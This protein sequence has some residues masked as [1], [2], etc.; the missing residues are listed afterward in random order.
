[1][2]SIIKATEAV[3][4]SSR[5]IADLAAARHNDVIATIDRLFNKGLLR[6]DRKSRI[7]Q[8]GGRPIAVYDLI[9]RDVYLVVAGYSDEIR[10][11]II[12]RWQELEAK[13]KAQASQPTQAIT[14]P[15]TFAQALRLAA[16]QAE[17][18]EQ[19]QALIEAQKPAVEF[20]DWFV[21]AKSAKGFRE[22]AKLL[23]VREREFIADLA[24]KKIIFKQ[25]ANWLPTDEHQHAGYFTVKTGEANGHAF[26][27][28]RFTPEGIAWIA[29]RYSKSQQLV[30]A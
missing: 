26:V 19:Q 11:R 28:T 16:D 10:A 15:Q 27:Q 2:L 13:Q 30:E 12:D 1:M 25:G 18:I 3:T 14:T 8:T 22:V 9:E 7:E 17:R 29:K 23:G 6:S 24:N 20:V 21:E 4:M 5:E